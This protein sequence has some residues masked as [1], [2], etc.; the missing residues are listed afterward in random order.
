MLHR[1]FKPAKCKTALKLATS[2]I[3]LMKNKK[4][5]HLKQ[6]KRE[7]AQLLESGQDQS[8]RIRVEHVV[9][10][11]KTIAA[12]DLLDIYCELIVARLPMIES[13]KNCPID[14]KEAVASVVFASPR[15]ADIPELQDVRKHFTAKYG[16]EFVNGAIELRPNSGVSRMLVEKLS[17]NAPDGQTKLKILSAIAE[18][19]NVL[20]DPKAFGEKESKPYDDLLKGPG[21]MFTEPPIVHAPPPPAYV[22]APQGRDQNHEA[23]VNSRQHSHSSSQNFA[24]SDFSGQSVPST[25][26][27]PP[28][29][30][31]GTEYEGTEKRQSQSRDDNSFSSGRQNWN[32]QFKDATA[33]AQA[34]AESAEQASM[35]ARAAAELASHGK[36]TSQHSKDSQNTNVDMPRKNY[37]SPS[38]KFG[39]VVDYNSPQDSTQKPSTRNEQVDGHV[40]ES[41]YSQSAY[42]KPKTATSIDDN[43]QANN[44]HDVDSPSQKSSH[45]KEAVTIVSKQSTEE[46]FNS[47]CPSVSSDDGYDY[48]SS[49]SHRNFVFD[50]NKDQFESE[51]LHRENVEIGSTE[52]IFDSYLDNDVIKFD[53][54]PQYDDEHGSNFYPASITREPSNKF[55]VNVDQG[56]SW[57][58]TS[59]SSEKPLSVSRVSADLFSPPIFDET[60]LKS[61]SAAHT[62]DV[63][64]PTFDD[65]DSEDELEKSSFPGKSDAGIRSFKENDLFRNS[66]ELNEGYGLKGSHFTEKNDSGSSSKQKLIYSSDDREELSSKSR[67][68]F[69]D[70]EITMKDE[71]FEFDQSKSESGNELKFPTVTGGIR[72]KGYKIPPYI[73]SPSGNSLPSKKAAEDTP[74]Y[75]Q[76]AP[77][78]PRAKSGSLKSGAEQNIK[79]KSNYDLGTDDFEEDLPQVNLRS[80]EKYAMKE[81]SSSKTRIKSYD[82]F[83]EEVPQPKLA[84]KHGRR[85]DYTKSK[86]SAPVGFFAPDDDSEED[87]PM[88]PVTNKVR[89]GS[90]FSR[91]TKANPDS[92]TSSYS[93][94]KRESVSENKPSVSENRSR[95]RPQSEKLSEQKPLVVDQ[96]SSPLKT[97][98]SSGTEPLRTSSGEAPSRESSLNKASHVHPKL[99]DYDSFAAHFQSLRQ[100]RN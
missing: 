95:S 36:V 26:P 83:E 19:H 58:K 38:E 84:N 77:T 90:G 85:E 32:M 1:S 25:A 64:P 34:A 46:H 35:A 53:K 63:A 8:A 98:T 56:S 47:Y 72:N 50:D 45:Q 42:P 16:K 4:E 70:D 65:A 40:A 62:D 3:K 13:Q 92:E 44:F 91:R 6:L 88:P 51:K 71:V 100:N 24:S 82:D 21:Q 14:L 60:S 31:S 29:R 52:A 61:P 81:N 78:S 27:H 39:K 93:R 66:D 11:E 15:C 37:E 97:A 54:Q 30:P 41:H 75:T 76:N 18:E 74:A 17:A 69:D 33:A 5:N 73:K 49:P 7:L 20:W 22:Y 99:P 67:P 2:R 68:K 94:P 96:P 10:E 59:G 86:F 87:L 48:N 12:Y 9:R 43:C 79:D 28:V 89:A 23:P 57:G 55:A 80:K